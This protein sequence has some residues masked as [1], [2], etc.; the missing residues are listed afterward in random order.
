MIEKINLFHIPFW[1]IQVINFEEKKKK[2]NKVLEQFPENGRKGREGGIQDFVTNRHS[3]RFG[4]VEKFVSI[5]GEEMEEFSREIKKDF[6]I[7]EIWSITYGKGDHHISHNHGSWG[8]TG[9]LYLDLPKD[10]PFT[11][12]IQPWNDYEDDT[13]THKKISILEGDIV[14]VP[15][16]VLHFSRP[17]KSNSKKRVISWDMKIVERKSEQKEK[18]FGT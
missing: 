8:L 5:M 1:K 14:I 10:S 11:D 9:I 18:S 13:V 7:H 15:S 12:Y 3:N 4:L 6:A 17:N 2:L 16:F